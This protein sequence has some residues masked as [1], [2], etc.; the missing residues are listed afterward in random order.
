MRKMILGLAAVTMTVPAVTDGGQYA[1]TGA[2]DSFGLYPTYCR[3][4]DLGTGV[5][6]GG[7]GLSMIAP[8]GTARGRRPDGA[9]GSG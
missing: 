6:A 5:S 4:R 9:G 2:A 7:L 1:V 8:R 3:V